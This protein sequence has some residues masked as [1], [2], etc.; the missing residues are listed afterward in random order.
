MLHDYHIAIYFYEISK[1]QHCFLITTR[2]NDNYINVVS[3][4]KNSSSNE[5]WQ[6]YENCISN[7]YEK[8]DDGIIIVMITEDTITVELKGEEG[9]IA[10]L[11]FS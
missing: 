11:R 2:N 3:Y 1:N 5:H 8:S 7:E 4:F 6:R 9:G 10:T